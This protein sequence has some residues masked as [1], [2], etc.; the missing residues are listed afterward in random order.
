L[1]HAFKRDPDALRQTRYWLEALENIATTDNKH[2]KTFIDSFQAV[3]NRDD[4]GYNNVGFCYLV[5]MGISQDTE[6]A[7]QW[8][9]IAAEK[10]SSNAPINL[11]FCQ[12][13]PPLSK[14]YT[15]AYNYYTSDDKKNDPEAQISLQR[16]LSANY[17]HNNA[18]PFNV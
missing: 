5:G 12:N 4:N 14:I 13:N 16:W 10:G 17:Y 11:S 18:E 3:I 2:I 1:N 15:N 6:Q 7:I 8:L 9:K